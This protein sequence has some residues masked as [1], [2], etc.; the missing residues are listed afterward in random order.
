MEIKILSDEDL[1]KKSSAKSGNGRKRN[2]SIE[3]IQDIENTITENLN[4]NFA[5][6]I[7][8]G[9]SHYIGESN[10]KVKALNVFLRDAVEKI[11]NQS[12]NKKVVLHSDLN[13]FW[14]LLKENQ[15]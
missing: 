2:F 15:Q 14:I 9:L 8:D 5:V 4:K 1:I 13:Q 7:S 3:Y 12:P 10:K 6:S 11:T